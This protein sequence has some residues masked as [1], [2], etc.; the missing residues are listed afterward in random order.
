MARDIYRQETGNP[1]QVDRLESRPARLASSCAPRPEKLDVA[2]AWNVVIWL[3]VTSSLLLAATTLRWLVN[4]RWDVPLMAWFAVWM[5]YFFCRY[6]VAVLRGRPETIRPWRQLYLLF[7]ASI[8]IMVLPVPFE[9]QLLITAALLI[10]LTWR[11]AE[12][13]IDLCLTS[14]VSRDI[15]V[16]LRQQ[17]K[18][19]VTIRLLI[20]TTVIAAAV[21]T[22]SAALWS[23]TATLVMLQL[24][25]PLTRNRRQT[26][27]AAREML[28]SWLAYN[29][30]DRRIPGVYFSTAGGYRDRFRL[31]GAAICMMSITLARWPVEWLPGFQEFSPV[32]FFGLATY[33]LDLVIPGDG[34]QLSI[35]SVVVWL[36][37]Y[38]LL[39]ASPTIIVLLFPLLLAYG[40]LREACR[41]RTQ[42]ITAEHWKPLI[43]Q[44]RCSIHR[45]ERDSLYMGRILSDGSPLLILRDV[46]REHAHFLGDSGSGKTSMGLNP[47]LEQIIGGPECSV[48]IVDLKAD[49]LE[50][51]ATAS[52]AAQERAHRTGQPMPVRYFSNQA[53]RSTFAFNPLTQSWFQ[54]MDHYV[55]TD[56]L[57]GALGLTYGSDY[58][59]GYYSSANSAVLSHTIRK[60]PDTQTFRDLARRI[61][62][63]AISADRR[64]LHPEIRKAGV[65][66]Q[67]VLDR[68][69]SFDALNVTG[70]TH[71]RDVVDAAIDF[72]DVFVRPQV[73]YFHL[74]STLGPGSSPEI[75]RLVAYS[76]LAASTQTERRHQVYLVID[77][78]QR[79]VAQNIEYMLQLARS[80]GVGV[81][82]ANQSMQDLRTARADLIPTIEANCR[83]RQWFAVSALEDR[84]RL[85]QSSGKTV[86][87]LEGKSITQTQRGPLPTTQWSQFIDDRLTVNDVLL[88]SDSPYL[89]IVKL[90]RGAGYA[91]YGGMSVVVESN[92]HITRDEFDRRRNFAWPGVTAGAFLPG[93]R[94]AVPAPPPRPSGPVTSTEVIGGTDETAPDSGSIL[95]SWMQDRQQ[96]AP[97]RPR[98]RRHGGD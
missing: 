60:F 69:G 73:L 3:T 2:A 62:E 37:G 14:P 6:V 98:R 78:F 16:R 13:W 56:I 20:A 93:T 57:C 63:I 32:P 35:L 39:L 9:L 31:T 11:F 51:L 29:R 94:T 43:E 22:R 74:S 27:D 54:S 59:E 95:D 70:A 12:H 80:M 92:Y 42:Q 47:W 5:L 53:G 55:R 1:L 97:P 77:E 85:V 52:L 75:A 65:H 79:M 68:L 49:S 90:S 40:P 67:T 66:V 25:W 21:L 87:M 10:R 61:G 82:I 72:R 17:W 86:D 28:V 7:S 88:A 15:A 89:S 46:F 23:L 91:Q 44:M 64:E 41:Y 4:H 76:L 48:I 36:L 26:I 8:V 50:L 83:Y 19:Y 58:G 33:L 38:I 84:Q 30:R 24:L 81:I 18:E 96:T 71:S 45:I 34:F